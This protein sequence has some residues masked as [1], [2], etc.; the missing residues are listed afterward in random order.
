MSQ[1]MFMD[2]DESPPL[3]DHDP[4]GDQQPP[5]PDIGDQG[6]DAG[7]AEASLSLDLQ[8]QPPSLSP[9][10]QPDRPPPSNRDVLGKNIYC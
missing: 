3:G 6:A 10:E 8:S 4:P 2:C 7:A 5:D 9:P 1:D